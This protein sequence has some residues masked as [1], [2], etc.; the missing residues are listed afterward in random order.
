MDYAFYNCATL[1]EV[2]IEDDVNVIDGT[3][4]HC[5]ALEKVTIKGN[6]TSINIAFDNCVSLKEITFT[7]ASHHICL[8]RLIMRAKMLI[9]L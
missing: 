9:K 1:K 5:W 2:T 8:M 3:F 6:V 4:V 7:Q